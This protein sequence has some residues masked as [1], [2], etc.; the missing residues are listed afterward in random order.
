MKLEELVKAVPNCYKQKLVDNQQEI[1]GLALD[2]RKVRPGFVF[3]AIRGAHQ[4]GHCYLEQAVKNGATLL[5]VEDERYLR[6]QFSS[7]ISVLVVKNSR[8]AMASLSSRFYQAPSS[9]MKVFGVTGTN[10]KTT[11]CFILRSVLEKTGKACGLLTTVKNVVGVREEEATNTTEESLYLERDLSAIREAGIEQVVI[12]VSSHGLALGRVQ[13]VKFDVATVTNL[14]PEHLEFHSNFEHYLQS[15]R[16]LLEKVEENRLKNYRR[17]IVFNSDDENCRKIY[18]GIGVPFLTFGA[19]KEA[20]VQAREI[21]IG[22]RKTTFSL[23]TPWGRENVEIP[24]SGTHNVM[25]ALAAA[26]TALGSGVSWE[27]VVEG[28]ASCQKVPGRWELV[29]AGQKFTVIVD[30]AHNWHGLEQILSQI[31]SLSRGRLI[32]VFG[33]GGERDRAKRPL[34]GEVCARYSDVCIITTDNPRGEDPL[35]TAED[36]LSGVKKV[37]QTKK[38]CY[39]IIVDRVEAIR[40]AFNLAQTGDVVLLAGKGPERF[41]IY[42]DF[43]VPHNDFWIAWQILKGER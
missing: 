18:S 41:Q 21:E 43:V 23:C 39:S 22:W 34:M 33:C 38:V 1:T 15:K 28:L 40:K 32:V 37:A 24:F 3:F 5:V 17:L 13:E 16:K 8:E 4:D 10:G 25:N 31:R 29:E 7:P 35:A 20:E 6:H 26:S 42:Q 30:F 19:G 36:A 11:T 12:E 27:A 2:S 14:V 9:A